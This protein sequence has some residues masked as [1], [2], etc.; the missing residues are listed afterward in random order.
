M[1]EIKFPIGKSGV[2]PPQNP[3]QSSSVTYM[4]H[5]QHTYQVVAADET[6]V[7]WCPNCGKTW[8]AFDGRWKEIMEPEQ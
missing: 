3:P 7:R 6:V 1:T 8:Y 4:P 2:I 5:H